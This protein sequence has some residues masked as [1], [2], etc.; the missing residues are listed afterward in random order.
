MEHCHAAYW[1]LVPTVDHIYPIALGGKDN[2]ENWATTSMIHNAIKSNWT[3]EQLNWKMH[4]AG[5]MK[6]YDGF[7]TAFVQLVEAD[8]NLLK[9]EYIKR[10]YK[11]SLNIL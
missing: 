8:E 7:S 4:D 2:E 3:L 9:D 1:E 5:N 6:E 10:W 11:L